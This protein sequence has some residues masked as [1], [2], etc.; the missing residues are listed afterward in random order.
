M[1]RALLG[2]LIVAGALSSIPAKA[3][4]YGAPQGWGYGPPHAYAQGPEWQQD[5]RRHDEY[6]AHRREFW[7]QQREIEARRAYEQGQR[8]AYAGGRYQGGWSYR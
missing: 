1:K 6:R 4:P 8:D 7:R 2:A 5:W 3:Q